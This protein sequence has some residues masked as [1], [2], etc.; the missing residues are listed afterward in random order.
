MEV[1]T[2]WYGGMPN[3]VG[4]LLAKRLKRFRGSYRDVSR[5]FCRPCKRGKL[6]S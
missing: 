6:Q 3:A 4:S 2:T 5:C 1:D